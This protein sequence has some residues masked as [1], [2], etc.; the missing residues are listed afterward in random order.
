MVKDIND[1]YFTDEDY[2]TF[3]KENAVLNTSVIRERRKRVQEKL[4]D[5]NRDV[6]Y[7]KILQGNLNLAIHSNPEH[8]TSLSYPCAFNQYR[9]DWLGIRY[10]RNSRDIQELTEIMKMYTSHRERRASEDPKLG[11]Q[12]YACLQ[13]NVCSTGVEVGIFHSVPNEAVDRTHMQNVVRYD[14]ELQEKIIEELRKIKGY[15]YI[16]TIGN[17]EENHIFDVDSERPEDFIAFYRNYDREGM[18]SQMLKHFPKY[19]E[20]ITEDK[21]A[22]TCYDIIEQLKPLYELVIW[23]RKGGNN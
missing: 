18:W 6:L 2:E 15:G 10:G 7:P 20:R 21:L 17:S 3:T 9:V 11:F 22:E 19:D 23:K 14:D 12:K 16:W 4:L 5:F 8:I 1:F 13:V